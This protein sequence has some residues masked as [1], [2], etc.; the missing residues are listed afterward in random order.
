[1]VEIINQ[2]KTLVDVEQINLTVVS[3]NE[4]AKGL[5]K[6]LGFHVLEQNETP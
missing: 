1:M 4:S 2:A 5:Y 6:S 3:S